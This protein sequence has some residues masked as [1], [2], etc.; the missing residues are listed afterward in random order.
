MSETFDFGDGNGPVPAH[1]HQNP[2]GSTGGWVAETVDISK[3]FAT[4]TLAYI[5]PD[6]LVYGRARIFGDV[7]IRG[8]S[9]I[10]G[11]AVTHSAVVEKTEDARWGAGWSAFRVLREDA[12]QQLTEAVFLWVF[13]AVL[14]TT[15]FGLTLSVPQCFHLS[16]W[17]ELPRKLLDLGLISAPEYLVFSMEQPAHELEKY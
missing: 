11:G 3:T 14:G 5:G 13:G 16:S 4:D 10:S 8:T 12:A 7:K 2:D 15:G 6:A 9:R 1:R 17:P